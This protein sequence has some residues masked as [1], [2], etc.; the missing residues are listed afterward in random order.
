MEW[1]SENLI[2]MSSLPRLAARERLFDCIDQFLRHAVIWIAGL[3][4]CG[5]TTPAAHYFSLPPS[6]VILFD[7]FLKVF[8]T[9]PPHQIFATESDRSGGGRPLLGQQRRSVVPKPSVSDQ[10]GH[11]SGNRMIHAWM[12]GMPCRCWIEAILL[13][14]GYVMPMF[15]ISR[16]IT[17]SC[18]NR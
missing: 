4:G 6:F 8:P 9:A 1:K 7:S 15:E 5:K 11:Y 12:H 3:H 2:R 18:M 14:K 10:C 16:S 13:G 17:R